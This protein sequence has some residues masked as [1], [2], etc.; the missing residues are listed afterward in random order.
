M[1]GNEE[2]KREIR[3]SKSVVLSGQSYIGQW[4]G[5]EGQ[6][7]R[8]EMKSKVKRGRWTVSVEAK[9]AR[10]ATVR[11][12]RVQNKKKSALRC[13]A[14]LGVGEGSRD[15]KCVDGIWGHSY[16]RKLRRKRWE[17]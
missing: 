16:P 1:N 6:R 13:P 14:L 8:R 12:W 3:Q 11:A 10:K 5:G 15:L 9:K 17:C 4:D 7:G 2:E